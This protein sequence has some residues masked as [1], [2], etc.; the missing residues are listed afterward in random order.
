M[1]HVR[2]D[3]RAA[4]LAALAGLAATGSRVL[5]GRDFDSHPLSDT[6]IGAGCLV[7][8]W[9]GET[10][11]NRGLGGPARRDTRAFTLRVRAVVKASSGYLELLDAIAL[12][13]EH[14]MASTGLIGGAKT[15]LYAGA[16]GP[17]I[18]Q[19]SERPVAGLALLFEVTYHVGV[20]APDQPL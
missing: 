2:A 18:S 14:R 5:P 11:P 7:V 10:V 12:Q 6:E 20:F 15:V 17:E 16:T 8:D 13:V 19:Q 4:Y 9:S 1:G 3:I